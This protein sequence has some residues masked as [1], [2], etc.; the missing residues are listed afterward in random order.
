[1]YTHALIRLITYWVTLTVRITV[2]FFSWICCSLPFLKGKAV[3]YFTLVWNPSS[4]LTLLLYDNSKHAN[5]VF[6]YIRACH[7][8]IS[9]AY[10]NIWTLLMVILNR[11]IKSELQ[12]NYSSNVQLDLTDSVLVQSYNWQERGI[13]QSHELHYDYYF[14]KHYPRHAE[15]N[16]QRLRGDKDDKGTCLCYWTSRVLTRNQTSVK[17][18]E[19]LS[20][21]LACWN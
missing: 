1:M 11:Y 8:Y 21:E 10:M 4:D 16:T 18:R 9:S 2:Q 14:I 20:A 12:G 13:G 3:T 17:A 7:N 15:D 5:K 19:D 6:S